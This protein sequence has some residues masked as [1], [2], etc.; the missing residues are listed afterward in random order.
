MRDA[1]GSP[2]SL[3]V[4]VSWEGFSGKETNLFSR[5]FRAQCSA[6]DL[7]LESHR[8][9]LM[10]LTQSEVRVFAQGNEGLC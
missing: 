1:I 7:N 9:G 3:T 8:N 6:C 4:C 5:I 2:L 10:P